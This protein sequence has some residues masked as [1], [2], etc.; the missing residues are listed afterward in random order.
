MEKFKLCQ[1]D[2]VDFSIFKSLHAPLSRRLCFKEILMAFG[3]LVVMSGQGFAQSAFDDPGIRD[4]KGTKGGDLVSV[5][6]KIDAGDVALGSSSQVVILM[7]ND[8]AKP[9]NTGEISLYPSSNVSATIAQ[10]ECARSPLPPD[11]V[12]AIALGVK[13]LQPGKFRIEMLM[14]H[15][16]R[17]K[18]LTSTVSGL[19]DVTNEDKRDIVRDLEM[20]P[21]EIK[22][23]DLKESRPLTRSIIL[24]NVTSKPIAISSMEIEAN[25]QA[26]YELKTDCENLQS[27]E[28][29]I[30]TVTW[31]PKQRGP[32]TGVLVVNHDGP[33]GVISVVLEGDYSPEDA[34]EV[35]V[36]PEAVP[37][38]GLL[39]ASQTQVSF[40]DDIESTSSITV[41]LVNVGD[42][43]I[44]LNKIRL[45]NEDSGVKVASKGCGAKTVLNPVEA[46]PLTLI[47]E[48]V[49][50][51]SILDD[52]QI[53]HD[54]AR[55]ILVLPITGSASKAVNQDSKAIVFNDDLTGDAILRAIEPISAKSVGAN[56]AAAKD[57]AEKAEVVASVRKQLNV[58]GSL[59]GYR[60]TS[61][62]RN[63]AIVSG[64]G[65][66]R[67]V[68]NGQ[69][70]VIGGTLWRVIVQSS[71]VQF[72]N[73]SQ[74]TL[75]LFDRSLAPF[76]S[77]TTNNQDT[78]PPA[79]EE[80][81]PSPTA[82]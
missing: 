60:I 56:D 78:S 45:S 21:N 26:G 81:P 19:V 1:E 68:F 77:G 37:G 12:C 20:I 43:P 73:G 53:L 3:L 47:W 58:T 49:R 16:G 41:S 46:C 9:I 71:A 42:T 2:I 57:K 62:A 11:A 30:S 22:F 70:T 48:P 72:A 51:G 29:C 13:G 82:N 44:T 18:L 61:L 39:T 75:L 24:R 36:F 79:G 65:G 33:T 64:P 69:E 25:S 17:A 67:V 50:E 8:G 27:G 63:R 38:K 10:N 6:A 28:A 14:R 55:G 76:N 31:S 59:E 40:G 5:S 34:K 54:G 35:G 7:R 4:A 66:S 32:S 15:D 80:L 74:K 52:V 23:G